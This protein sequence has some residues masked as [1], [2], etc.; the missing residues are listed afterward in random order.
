MEQTYTP[1]IQGW[2]HLGSFGH[3]HC[4]CSLAPS[5][6]IHCVPQGL[7]YFLLLSHSNSYTFPLVLFFKQINKDLP[8]FSFSYSSI[9]LS[10]PILILEIVSSPCWL[11]V[12]CLITPSTP[13]STC[14]ILA[15]ASTKE[16]TCLMITPKDDS[17]TTSISQE[18]SAVLTTKLS[19]IAKAIWFSFIFSSMFYVVFISSLLA[20]FPQTR[21]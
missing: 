5:D 13:S 21:L 4:L 3:V 14:S 12:S 16:T 15:Y 8:Y 2:R 9:S 20:P 7:P 6:L 17:I 18:Q 10:I 1:L 11:L 19:A